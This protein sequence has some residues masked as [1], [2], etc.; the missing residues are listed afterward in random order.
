MGQ[1]KPASNEKAQRDIFA[2]IV[3]VHLMLEMRSFHQG[4]NVCEGFYGFTD[5]P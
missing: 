1:N 5:I 3:A 4:N 2:E